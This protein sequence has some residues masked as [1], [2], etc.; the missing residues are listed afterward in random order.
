MLLAATGF[1]AGADENVVH[2]IAQKGRQYRVVRGDVLFAEGSA[3]VSLYLVVRGRIAI[4]KHSADNRESIVALMQRGALFGE[5]GLIDGLA[6]SATAQAH[7][8]SDVI[9]LPYQPVRDAVQSNPMLLWG[10]ARLLAERLRTIEKVVVDSVFLD[11]TG[12]TAKRLLELAGV[13]NDFVLPITQKELA[14]MIGCS[15]ERVNKALGDLIYLGWLERHERSYQI[16][17][18]ERLEQ[19]SESTQPRRMGTDRTERDS[20]ARVLERHGETVEDSHEVV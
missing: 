19:R 4:I 16:R 9:E 5:L 11:V 15:R 14:G 13:S 18:R 17:N 12:R 7:E 1:L 8:P 3:A 6:S 20:S 2:A 10:I